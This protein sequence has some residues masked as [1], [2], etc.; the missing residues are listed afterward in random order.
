MLFK[1]CMTLEHK[2]YGKENIFCV[3][4][5]EKTYKGL[6]KHTVRMSKSCENF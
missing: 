5:I 6:K 2:T 3:S 4:R 1:P